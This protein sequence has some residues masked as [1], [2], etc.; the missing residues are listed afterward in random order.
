[1][2]NNNYEMVLIESSKR[3]QGTSTSFNFSLSRP[4]KNIYRIDLLYASLNNTFYTF[5]SPDVFKWNEIYYDRTV[6]E[7]DIITSLI[8]YELPPQSKQFYFTDSSLSI[9][10][11]A[12]YIETQM[13]NQTDRKEYKVTYDASNFKLIIQNTDTENKKFQLD[14]SHSNS[15]YKKAGFDK[16]YMKAQII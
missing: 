10:E 2:N 7:I 5:R 15:V 8:T 16:N 12:D 14:F 9:D 6:G 3:D 1:M 13:N 4:I 11:F